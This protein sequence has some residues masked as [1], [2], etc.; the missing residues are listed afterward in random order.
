MTAWVSALFASSD[1]MIGDVIVGVFLL[2][3]GVWWAIRDIDWPAFQE[4][5]VILLVTRLFPFLDLIMI[6]ILLK[7]LTLNAGDG[8]MV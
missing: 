5:R 7:V 2:Q 4:L 8:P 6:F 3:F 1:G